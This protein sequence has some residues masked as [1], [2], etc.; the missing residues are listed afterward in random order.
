MLI[1]PFAHSTIRWLL[2]FLYH[3]TAIQWVSRPGFVTAY[4]T[5]WLWSDRFGITLKSRN[6]WSTMF[7]GLIR[8]GYL[9]HVP[10]DVHGYLPLIIHMTIWWDLKVRVKPVSRFVIRHLV[11]VVREQSIDVLRDWRGK[12][13]SMNP[14]LDEGST[15]RL[16]GIAFNEAR[17]SMV[18]LCQGSSPRWGIHWTISGLIPDSVSRIYTSTRRRVTTE[19]PCN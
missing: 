8:K 2:C 6:A 18:C 10:M 1:E 13:I 3:L 15:G 16:F 11:R 5:R 17:H 12:W 7:R 9:R 14:L 19:H 4:Q